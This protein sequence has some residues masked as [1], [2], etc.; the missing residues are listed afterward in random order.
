MFPIIRARWEA[1]VLARKLRDS[2]AAPDETW[3]VGADE[4]GKPMLS[5]ANFRVVLAP[6]AARLFDAIHLYSDDA[7]VWLPLFARLRLRAA[8]R[9]RL[10]HDASEHLPQAKRKK[11]PARRRRAQRT[12]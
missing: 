5:N 2:L 8:A 10:I 9:W 11:T 4:D 6:R 12:A 1:R 7:E 3:R